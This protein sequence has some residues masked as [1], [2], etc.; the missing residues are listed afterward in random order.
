MSIA[1]CLYSNTNVIDNNSVFEEDV[2]YDVGIGI[3]TKS[4]RQLLVEK[5]QR[6]YKEGMKKKQ[7][8][9]QFHKD[10]VEKQ[11]QLRKQKYK[12]Y[13]EKMKNK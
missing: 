5:K 2:I 7:R 3:Q 4:N 12:E 13:K 6:E 1:F 8:E 9:S 11:K 10:Y